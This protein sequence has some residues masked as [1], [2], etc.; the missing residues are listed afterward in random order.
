MTSGTN[1]KG[2]NHEYSS[3]FKDTTYYKI[4][5]RLIND[6]KLLNCAKEN[7]YRLIY[8]IH[9]ILSPQIGD[10]EANDVVEIIPGSEVNYEKILTESA[11]MVTDHSGIMYDFAYQRKPLV[12]YHPDELPPQYGEGG[13]KYDTMG[14]GPVCKDNDSVVD[15]ICD[16]MIR[17][18]TIEQKYIDRINDFFEFDDFNN[19]ERVYKAAVEFQKNR[20]SWRCGP[21]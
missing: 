19:C 3:N 16:I 11:L 12:Y 6:E 2:S 7:G 1:K 4:Y 5:N 17:G 20:G 15:A 14:F 13:L 10:F 9:P 18:C 21:V 8:L